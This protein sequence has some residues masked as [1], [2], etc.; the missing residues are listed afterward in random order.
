MLKSFRKETLCG[1]VCVFARVRR[2]ACNCLILLAAGCVRC[3]P[4]Y[5]PGH[6]AP[7]GA[8]MSWTR[9]EFCPTAA[10]LEG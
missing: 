1:A 3:V 7:S 10:G 5:P 4:P 2:V 9:N 6:A 8:R